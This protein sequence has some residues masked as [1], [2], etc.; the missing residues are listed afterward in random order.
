[1]PRF[2]GLLRLPGLTGLPGYLEMANPEVPNHTDSDNSESE[3][4]DE[5]M[6]EKIK[7]YKEQ[8]FNALKES[9]YDLFRK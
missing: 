1:M 9:M 4:E 6:D 7:I 3:S 8:I 5:N 2:P